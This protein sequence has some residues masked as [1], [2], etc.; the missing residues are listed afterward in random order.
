MII[1]QR[2]SFATFEDLIIEIAVTRLSTAAAKLPAAA[3]LT[4]REIADELIAR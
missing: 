2:S 3:S 1:L 4:A